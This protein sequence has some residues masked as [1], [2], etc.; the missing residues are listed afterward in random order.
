MQSTV[1]Q[2]QAKHAKENKARQGERDSE[3]ERERKQGRG[4]MGTAVEVRFGGDPVH[5]FHVGLCANFRVQIEP[6]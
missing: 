1:K 2:G 6:N 5:L 3:S 4:K